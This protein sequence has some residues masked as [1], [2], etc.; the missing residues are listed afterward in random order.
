LREVLSNEA[1]RRLIGGIFHEWGLWKA[2]FCGPD[3]TSAAF[4]EGLR[5]AAVGLAE[6]IREI[7]PLIL[8]QCEIDYRRF[9]RDTREAVEND[10]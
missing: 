3:A 5:S 10:E 1:G 8:A 2:I 9:E 7:D 6:R 4:H